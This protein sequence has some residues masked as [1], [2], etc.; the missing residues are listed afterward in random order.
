MIDKKLLEMLVCP[1]SKEPLEYDRKNQEL[2]CEASGLA[3]A[4]QDGIPIMI[5]ERARKLDVVSDVLLESTG[6]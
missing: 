3:Y 6:S 2:I 5:R 1:V 4:I